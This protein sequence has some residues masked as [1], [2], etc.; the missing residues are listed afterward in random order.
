MAKEKVIDEAPGG[1]SGPADGSGSGGDDD[2]IDLKSLSCGDLKDLF[3]VVRGQILVEIGRQAETPKWRLV[4]RRSSQIT[5]D[6]LW[7]LANG[8]QL[9]FIDRPCSGSLT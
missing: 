7:A 3:D 2:D 9:E 4:M 1:G 8:I 5:I 6:A